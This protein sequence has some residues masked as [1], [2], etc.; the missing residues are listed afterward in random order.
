MNSGDDIV[1]LLTNGRDVTTDSAEGIGPR[2]CAKSAR[3]FLFDLDHAHI[4][5]G[6]V[7]VEGDAEI[8]HEGQ[9]LSL[10][11]LKA[12]EQVSGRRLFFA[13]ALAPVPGL[14]GGWRGRGWVGLKALTQQVLVTLFIVSDTVR[15]KSALGGRGARS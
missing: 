3:D 7:V 11:A 9:C 12:V 14:A 1:A 6:Q 8:M 5:F 13:P 4:A 15:R 10:I 2:A